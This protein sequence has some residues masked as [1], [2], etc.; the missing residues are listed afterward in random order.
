M[1]FVSLGWSVIEMV[2]VHCIF[3]YF[4]NSSNQD[5]FCFFVMDYEGIF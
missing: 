1:L 4:F 2:E 5:Y 3:I